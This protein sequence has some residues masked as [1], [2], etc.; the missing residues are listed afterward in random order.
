M[1]NT[2]CVQMF[3]TSSTV[4]NYLLIRDGTPHA[5]NGHRSI[6]RNACE[7][8]SS[9]SRETKALLGK[10]ALNNAGPVGAGNSP[11]VQNTSYLTTAAKTP[12]TTDSSVARRG[13][14]NEGRDTIDAS[15]AGDNRNLL[16]GAGLRIQC[17][18]RSQK[19][20]RSETVIP[21]AQRP[22][23]S[24]RLDWISKTHTS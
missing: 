5:C 1:F 9:L 17:I 18:P 4:Q 23:K 15:Q 14:V 22:A 2:V 7:A 10:L 16:R 12:P 13:G 21:C 8:G 3:T 19:R 11:G 20:R 24:R 6:S